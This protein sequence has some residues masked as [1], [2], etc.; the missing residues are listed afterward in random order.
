MMYGL[1]ES[2]EVGGTDYAIRSDFRDVL[3][4]IGVLN[5]LELDDRERCFL[6]L[7]I[8]YRDFETMPPEHYQEALGHCFWFLNGGHSDEEL[9]ENPPRLMDWEQDF[10]V[11]IAPVNR[12]L[13][14]DAR[15]DAH[16]HW[17]TFLGAYMEIGDCTFAQVVHIREMQRQGKPL[18]KSD[19]EWYRK[20]KKLVDLKQELTSA[21]LETIKRWG[22]V[23]V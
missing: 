11:I 17:W 21:E 16:L 20:N 9:E 15:A 8:F 4:I 12:V 18:D 13:G 22:G 23:N 2:L 19:R 10:P 14:H 5:D 3:E 6:A 7:L 1:P